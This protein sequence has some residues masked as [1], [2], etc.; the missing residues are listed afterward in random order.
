MLFTKG[1]QALPKNY[2][3]IAI[4]PVFAKLYSMLIL[5]RIQPQIDEGFPVE[6]AGF[7]PGKGCA[8][9]IHTVR[10]MAEKSK[11]WGQ[12]VW[13]ASLDLEKA[14]D[15]VF[16][17]AVTD[18]LTSSGVAQGYIE[19][20]ADMYANLSLY[21]E[22]DGAT[23]SRDVKVQRGVRQGDPLSPALFNLVIPIVLRRVDVTWQ[24]RQ[25]GGTHQ[26]AE[27]LRI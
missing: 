24:R 1:D 19:A 25:Y 8:D 11:E 15:K 18:S 16:F 14:F 6:Q 13:A 3:P 9:H 5:S 12:T 17:E 20:V 7:R 22:L 2:R 23:T 26:R 4:I 10:M 27:G 21:V